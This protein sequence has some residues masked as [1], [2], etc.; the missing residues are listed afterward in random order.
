MK[1]EQTKYL[2]VK[3]A[4]LW[5]TVNLCVHEEAFWVVFVDLL[6]EQVDLDDV[7]DFKVDVQCFLE[8]LSDVWARFLFFLGGTDASFVGCS[9]SSLF[10]FLVS[11][12]CCVLF[13]PKSSWLPRTKC[14]AFNSCTLP[15]KVTVIQNNKGTNDTRT[16]QTKYHPHQLHQQRNQYIWELQGIHT[17]DLRIL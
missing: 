9:F 10:S 13:T 17:Q 12:G 6:R 14:S 5:G 1:I 16:Y 2:L 15:S 11:F 3:R 8:G 4:G 7:E